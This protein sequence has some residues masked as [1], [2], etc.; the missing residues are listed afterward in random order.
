MDNELVNK[1][2]DVMVEYLGGDPKSHAV[3]QDFSRSEIENFIGTYIDYLM[4]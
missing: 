3:A 4:K 2:N 1:I